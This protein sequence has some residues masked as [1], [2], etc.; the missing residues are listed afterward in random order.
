MADIFHLALI[1]AF[2]VKHHIADRNHGIC[3]ILELWAGGS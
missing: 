3:D 2:L 1:E